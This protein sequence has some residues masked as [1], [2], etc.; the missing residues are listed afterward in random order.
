MNVLKAIFGSKNEPLEGIDELRTEFALL[1]SRVSV[2]EL[3][4]VD[5]QSRY[6]RLRAIQ[7]ADASREARA[8]PADDQGAG[9][10]APA[11]RGEGKAALRKRALSKLRANGKQVSVPVF[12]SEES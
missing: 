7:A 2:V 5:V 6:K 10:A 11:I 9:I 4:L 12:D 8:A 1:R 3:E